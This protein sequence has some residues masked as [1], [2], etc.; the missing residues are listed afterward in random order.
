MTHGNRPRKAKE[1]LHMKKLKLTPFNLK[2]F[3]A[4]SS[5]GSEGTGAA[6]GVQAAE[7][8]ADVKD[9]IE[10]VAQRRQKTGDNGVLF[11][12][13]EQ[14]LKNNEPVAEAEVE[15]SQE[16]EKQEK[17]PK[18][19]FDEFFRDAEMKSIL[20]NE[21]QKMI[22]RR[23]RETQELKTQL[24]K[25]NE[26]L[27][28]LFARYKVSDIDALS[29][30]LE[31]DQSFWEEQAMEMG[32]NVEQYKQFRQHER[33]AKKAQQIID[34]NRRQ[35]QARQQYA[36]WIKEAEDVRAKYP[37][38]DLEAELE[39][40][41]FRGLIGQKNPEYSINMLQAYEICHMDDIKR[42]IEHQTAQKTQQQVV[43]N[44]KARGTRPSEGAL[45]QGAGVVVKND[46]SK[47]SKEERA[48]IAKRV[49]RGEKISF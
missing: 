24:G 2:L 12:K 37:E 17:S 19:R 22:N 18:E 4:A 8:S 47:L 31:E 15:V 23:F 1:E 35:E 9:A 33:T 6:E 25:Q 5:S 34:S 29:H 40:P 45:S 48:E 39:N 20:T 38:F 26:V 16:G 3:D 13:Q 21:N 28:N 7:Q 10:R 41:N 49:L 44:V 11:G 30:A 27:E 46:V 36:T 42:S 43:D 32:M 14:T